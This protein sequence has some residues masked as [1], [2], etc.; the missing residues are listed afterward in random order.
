MPPRARF[1]DYQVLPTLWCPNFCQK[2]PLSCCIFWP[3]RRKSR[4][5][6]RGAQTRRLELE[7]G[8]CSRKAK[9]F[10]AEYFMFDT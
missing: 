9:G 5:R 7:K 4:T 10:V 1:P 8:E 6:D 2:H 3:W